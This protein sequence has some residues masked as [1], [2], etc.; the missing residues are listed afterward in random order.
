MR[1]KIEKVFEFFEVKSITGVKRRRKPV[2]N[3]YLIYLVTKRFW[4]II[5]EK[6][7]G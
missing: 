4:K 7:S 1:L 2:K 3:L 5:S 6:R